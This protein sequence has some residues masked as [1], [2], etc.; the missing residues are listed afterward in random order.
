MINRIIIAALIALIAGL[1]LNAQDP[2]KVLPKNYQLVYE[3]A[4]VCVI[5]VHLEPHET[6][7]VHDHPMR[8]TVYVYLSAASPVRFSHLETH[9]FTVVRPPVKQGGFRVSPGR[10]EKHTVE[11]LGNAASDFLR[12]ELKTVPLGQ[13]AISFRGDKPFD[14][15]KEAVKVEFDSP[16]LAVKR[17]VAQPGANARH[18]SDTSPGLLIAFTPATLSTAAPHH[19]KAGDVVWAPAGFDLQAEPPGAHLLWITLK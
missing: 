8:P 7:P 6:L 5:H 2:L 17:I 9:A 18:Y 1:S 14:L 4:S 19:L 16:L 10:I 12:I 3:N 15:K 13:Q 11:N